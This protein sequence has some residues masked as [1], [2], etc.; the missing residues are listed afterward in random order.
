[1]AI[2]KS[3]PGADCALLPAYL[4]RGLSLL[5]IACDTSGG[6]VSKQLTIPSPFFFPWQRIPI[7]LGGHDNNVY[8]Q[9]LSNIV[10]A[11]Y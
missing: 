4:I 1:M 5:Q 11:N 8:Q 7:L 6:G 2:L 9:P 10:S 3:D